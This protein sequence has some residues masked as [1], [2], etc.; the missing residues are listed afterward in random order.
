M[1]ASSPDI[2]KGTIRPFTRTIVRYTLYGILWLFFRMRVSGVENI[3]K[4]GPFILIG[5]HLH[6][7]DP[8]MAQ[9]ALPRNC[10]FFVKQ[11]VF[12]FPVISQVARWTGGF[13][14]NRGAPDR[15]AIRNAEAAL[16]A[17]LGLGI[18]PEGTRSTTWALQKGLSGA[19]LI[20]L[21]NDVPIVPITITGSE[22][23]PFNGKK[24]KLRAG[25]TQ[26]KP[27]DNR[28]RLTFGPPFRLESTIDG[29][30]IT[31]A[32]ATDQMMMVLA[33]MLPPE[34]R[35]YYADRFDSSEA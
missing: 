25:Q 35:G 15:Q 6:N 7:I 17:G 4:A 26:E 14:V 31:A 21:R 5:N 20:A 11:E 1:S 24:G 32:E 22:R 10:H 33:R 29:R 16:S 30:R 34:Y 13:P 12:D 2:T 9:V 27:N 18:Y 19:G 28:T 23:L 3:P 8:M